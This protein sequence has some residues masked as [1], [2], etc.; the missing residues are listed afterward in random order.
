MTTLAD[1]K[2]LLERGQRHIDFAVE[3][4]NGKAVPMSDGERALIDQGVI[5]F[6]DKDFNRRRYLII[7][8]AKALVESE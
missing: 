3:H 4:K 8:D 5:W 6:Q 1:V 7:Q 2:I